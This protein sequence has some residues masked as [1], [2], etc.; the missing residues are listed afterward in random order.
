M[1]T[2]EEERNIMRRSLERNSDSCEKRFGGGGEALVVRNTSGNNTEHTPANQAVRK[3]NA[4]QLGIGVIG[5]QTMGHV[6]LDETGTP[7]PS[8][9]CDM[10]PPSIVSDW[11]VHL[12]PSDNKKIMIGPYIISLE[13]HLPPTSA[14]HPARVWNSILHSLPEKLVPVLRWQYERF[15][16]EDGGQC[17]PHAPPLLPG[18]PSS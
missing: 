11:S 6:D 9:T 12:V 7:A 13:D 18:M 1:Y 15:E 10:P 16:G 3:Y 2:E 4:Q 8:V 5:S 17:E 14:E